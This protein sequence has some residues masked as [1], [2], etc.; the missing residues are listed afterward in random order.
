MMYSAHY[1]RHFEKHQNEI[2]I[3]SGRTFRATRIACSSSFRCDFVALYVHN[4]YS[5]Q[6]PTITF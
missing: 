6:Q 5:P 4:I 3:I 2:S 1:L